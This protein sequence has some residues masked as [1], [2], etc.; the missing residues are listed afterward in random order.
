[1][2][3]QIPENIIHHILF[4]FNSF[5][6]YSRIIYLFNHFLLLC[7]QILFCK[8]GTVPHKAR[9]LKSLPK[10]TFFKLLRSRRHFRPSHRDRLLRLQRFLQRF[11]HR[12]GSALPRQSPVPQGKCRKLRYMKLYRRKP[13][14]LPK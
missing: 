4:F 14:N 10:N 7:T 12:Q 13:Q 1:M 9:F 11:L 8:K 6:Y 2:S 5:F 3:V